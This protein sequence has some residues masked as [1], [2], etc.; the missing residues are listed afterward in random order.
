MSRRRC[1]RLSV[2]WGSVRPITSFRFSG[3]EMQEAPRFK[4]MDPLS[5]EEK[6]ALASWVID[7]LVSRMIILRPGEMP[8]QEQYAS[9][10]ASA[11]R[12]AR[13]R[14]TKWLVL[15]QVVQTYIDVF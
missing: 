2:S 4:D 3:R 8:S 6:E 11:L 5:A 12:T 15:P 14:P 9:V 10:L 1:G 13:K 7:V